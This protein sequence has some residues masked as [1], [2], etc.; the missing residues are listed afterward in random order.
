MKQFR[1]YHLAHGE[2]NFTCFVLPCM[3]RWPCKNITP[4]CGIGKKP[5]FIPMPKPVKYFLLLFV[6]AGGAYVFFC[7]SFLAGPKVSPAVQQPLLKSRWQEPG[8]LNLPGFRPGPL[9]ERTIAFAQVLDY[10]GALPKGTVKL[11]DP[12]GT[13]AEFNLDTL[14]Q[15]VGPATSPNQVYQWGVAAS[16]GK[17]FGTTE[18]AN[19][20]APAYLVERHFNVSVSRTIS[21]RKWVPYTMEKQERI[22]GAEIAAKRPLVMHLANLNGQD[23][24]VVIDGCKYENNRFWVHLNL[25]KGGRGNGWY[26]FYATI[27]EKGD[28]ALR[29]IYAI[30]PQ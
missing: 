12:Y 21:W 11:L 13:T 24:T 5:I 29:V 16:L 10:H 19:G 4:Y 14:S 27:L 9:G 30:R 15:L 22:I 18:Y 28:Q 6:L 3:G 23:H 17:K 8:N 26:R 20:L 1:F 25:G 7:T 2:I